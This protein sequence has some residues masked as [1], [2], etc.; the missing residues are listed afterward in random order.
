MKIS[1][2]K[3]A[4]LTEIEVRK[5]A[6]K[7]V[8][9]YQNGLNLFFTENEKA[10]KQRN[11]DGDRSVRGVYD[12]VAL[13]ELLV[14]FTQSEKN[15]AGYPVLSAHPGGAPGNFLAA[16][17]AYGKKTAFIACVGDD[18]FGRMLTQTIRQAGID[19]SGVQVSRDAFTTLAFVTLDAHGDRTFSFARKP[20]ADT[21]L[22]W[23]KIDAGQIAQT[24]VFHFGTLSC[25]QD[26]VW[27]ATQRAVA[28]AK[29]HGAWITFDPN[30]RVSLWPGEDLARERM[31]WGLK[32][33][34]IVKI[35]DE[36]LDFLWGCGAED[37]AGRVLTLGAKL[38][39]V[40]CGAHGC[41]LKTA[42]ASYR[43]GCPAVE[44]V[45]TTGAGDIFGGSAAAKLL[46][47]GKAPESL[48]QEELAQ[49]AR[50][51]VTAASLSTEKFGGIPSIPAR[52]RVEEK[53]RET[54]QAG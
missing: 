1:S 49:I 9:S 19:V 39:M 16:L 2:V 53:M 27:T 40:T 32:Q 17:S 30:Y 15:E 52:R 13:G 7:I 4:Y 33:A 51:A 11:F 22:C 41:L 47:L 34:D 50:F 5:Y 42:R 23:E 38:V 54:G 12:V 35:S 46:E 26:P 20:G 10:V 44:P 37:G 25:T 48:E 43:C 28:Y 24:R 3:R 6:P 45:D 8:R 14:D 36:E 31:L 29:A 21:Q 18:A